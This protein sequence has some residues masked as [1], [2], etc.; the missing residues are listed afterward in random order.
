MS[1]KRIIV[2]SIL[3]VAL[4]AGLLTLKWIFA[5]AETSV[6]SEKAD[7]TI[8]AVNLVKQFETNEAEANTKYLD[9]VLF[10]TGTVESVT[11]DAA[12]INVTL[13]NPG[14]I[15]GVICSF[16]KTLTQAD[17]FVVGQSVSIKGRCTGYLMDVVL[18][19]CALAE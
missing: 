8:D 3:I 16:D 7:I 4:L 13:K 12:S 11:E 9:K 1:R 18:N 6:V 5:P 17:S 10:I 19:D 15:S 14:E 2:I